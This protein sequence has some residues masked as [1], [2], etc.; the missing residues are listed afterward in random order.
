CRAILSRVVKAP[1]VCTCLTVGILL[2]DALGWEVSMPKDIHG[3]KGSCLVIPCSFSYKSNPPKNPRRVVWYQWVSTG[4]PLVY[5]AWYPHDVIGK[6]RGKTDLYGKSDWDCS[7]LIKNLEPSHNG[8]K[9]YTRIDPE[10]IAWQNYETDDATSTVLV[11]GVHHN[12]SIEPELADVTEG[13]AQNFTCTIYHSC[14]KDN[15]AITWNY[16]NM[17]VLEWNKKHSDLDH[18]WVAFSNITFLGAKEDHGKKLICTAKFSGG[19]IE[20]YVVL[21]V[22]LMQNRICVLLHSNATLHLSYNQP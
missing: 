9:L 12:I 3:L 21:H 19:N 16:E 22:K 10:N 17:Q 15:P 8:E 2:Y 5:D 18:F 6:F 11:D 4:Y 1:F 14:Q 7:L 13:V 20:T